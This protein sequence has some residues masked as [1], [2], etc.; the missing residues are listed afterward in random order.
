VAIFDSL[1]GMR[2]RCLLAGLSVTPVVVTAA[3]GEIIGLDG[4]SVLRPNANVVDSGPNA[5][6]GNGIADAAP[7]PTGTKTCNGGPVPLDDPRYG[8]ASSTCDACSI[9]FA[10]DAK[11][12]GGACAAA[13]C[14]A[15]RADCNGRPDDGCEADLLSPQTCGSCTFACPTTTPFCGSDSSGAHCLS[16]CPAG[17]T[18]CGNSCVDLTK[19][20]EHCGTCENQCV[21]TVPNTDPLCANS[22]CTTQ[23]RSGLALCDP[24]DPS[25]GCGTLQTFYRDGD[26]DQYGDP[27]TAM[28]AC[29]PPS[30]YV[31]QAGDCDDT[32]PKVHQGQTQFFPTAYAKATGGFSYDYDCSGREEE[33]PGF[34][35]FT[36]CAP[37]PGCGGGGYTPAAA[38]PGVA[39]PYCGSTSTASCSATMSASA[40]GTPA[41]SC[42]TTSAIAPALPCH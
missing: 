38:Q 9:P 13:T 3:C 29:A 15:G 22:K 24:A 31:S 1:N 26:Q 25:K 32:Q 19:S 30:G 11:C 12:S 28:Q 8:C 36:Q 18:A 35:H 37:P 23:C 39:D 27:A 14:Q 5:S 10:H 33:Q 20:T 6:S 41:P 16:T 40:T 4:D 2:A 42:Y 21:S 17:Q 7:N 34:V